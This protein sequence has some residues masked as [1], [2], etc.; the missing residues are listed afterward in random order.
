MP[1]LADLD[2]FPDVMHSTG[3]FIKT[4][5][6][7]SMLNNC[8]IK[9]EKCDTFM[10]ALGGY[11]R[12]EHFSSQAADLVFS[13]DAVFSWHTRLAE[14]LETWATWDYYAQGNTWSKTPDYSIQDKIA[15]TIL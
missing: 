1:L 8:L 14:A 4:S 9:G 11:V 2:V 5:A 10:D 15:R 13:P 6:S 3:D 12:K 7:A